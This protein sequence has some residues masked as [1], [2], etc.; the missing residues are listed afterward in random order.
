MIRADECP[1]RTASRVDEARATMTAYIGK[2]L[3]LPLSVPYDNQRLASHFSDEVV[4]ALGNKAMMAERDPVTAEQQ[5]EFE[6]KNIR[7]QIKFRRQAVSRPVLCDRKVYRIG[8]ASNARYVR[9]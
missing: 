9:F 5:A 8:L 2:D 6:F 1:D 7:P 4:A 3:D